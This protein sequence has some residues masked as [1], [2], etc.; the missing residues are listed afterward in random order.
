MAKLDTFQRARLAARSEP[1][2]QTYTLWH[3][4]DKRPCYFMNCSAP[5]HH[6]LVLKGDHPHSVGPICPT[7]AFHAFGLEAWNVTA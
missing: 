3:I 2:E 5:T 7:C 1:S 6:I 4:S